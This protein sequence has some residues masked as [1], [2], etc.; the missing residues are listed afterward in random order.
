MYIVNKSVLIEAEWIL[1]LDI[2]MVNKKNSTFPYLL[3][4]I[5]E[6]VRLFAR[7]S[8]VQIYF[9]YALHFSRI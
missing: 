2:E 8:A 7:L 4:L 6:H 5:N 1:L 3:Y 9:E